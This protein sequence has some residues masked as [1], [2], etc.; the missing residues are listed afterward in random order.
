MAGSSRE[1]KSGT[2]LSDQDVRLNRRKFLR[3]AAV[4]GAAGVIGA[5]LDACG[6]SSSTTVPATSAATK[7]AAS[8]AAPTAAATSAA[9]VATT[10]AASAAAPSTAASNASAAAPAG[11]I[12]I[13]LISNPTPNPIVLPGGLSSIL[14]DKNLFGQ[15]VRPEANTGAPSPDLAQ[16]WDISPDG[17]TY[18]FTLRPGVKWHNGDPFTADDVKFT[19]DLMQDKKSNAAF[20]NNLGPF[21]GADIVDPMTVR[22]NLSAPYAPLLTQLAYNV[23][24]MPKKVLQ[25]QD[26]NQPTSFIQTPIGTGPYKW[27]EFVSGD[28]VTLVANTDYWDG[29]PKIGTVVYKIL[30]DLNTQVAQLRAG[31]VDIVMLEPSQIDALQNVPNVVINAANQTNYQYLSMSNSNPLFSDKRVRQALSYALDRPTFVTSILRGK[32]SVANGPIS[33]PMQWAY[34]QDQQPFPY[35]TKKAQDL[36]TQAGWQMQ[37][38]KLMKDGQPFKFAIMLDVGNPTRKDF[39]LV[40]QQ[41]Y[42]KLGM[43]VS[44]DSQEF[45]KWYDRSSKGDYDMY[46][47][48]WITPAD[49]DALYNGYSDDNTDHYK[50]PTVDDLFAQG[51]VTTAPDARKPIYAKLQQMLYDDQPDV[52]LTYPPEYRAFSKRVQGYTNLGIRDALYYTYKW[53][54]SG[55]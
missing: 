24:M 44:I 27:K 51:K 50:N 1:P 21:T 22:L 34:P 29:P 25:G 8:S 55:A 53:T 36:L 30:P 19:F 45:N 37:G 18:T 39:A 26:I 14:L 54:L 11:T 16:K 46:V 5:L 40:A 33:P 28:H 42:Q 17:K 12:T 31:Q 43:D 32:G 38:G 49:P 7:A 52:F 4:V 3:G 6:S 41:T 23:M 10:G 20:I 35:D 15:L 48:Y 9:A 47:A 2:A 13:P